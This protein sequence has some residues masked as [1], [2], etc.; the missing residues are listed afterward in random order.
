MPNE[1]AAVARALSLGPAERGSHTGAVGDVE[2]VATSTGIGTARAAEATARLFDALTP[3][4][5]MVVGIAGGVDATRV[6]AV[7]LPEVV[8]DDGTGREYRPSPLGEHSAH[9]ASGRLSTSDEYSYSSARIAE[10][11]AHGVVAVDMETAAV[12]AVCEER[13][14]PWSVVRAIS[15]PVVADA[16]DMV[17]R[18]VHPDGSPNVPAALRYTLT[19]PWRIPGLVR[20]GRDASRACRAAA[21]G[22]AEQI[23]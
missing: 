19:H 17:L 10:L 20:L 4:H 6:G 14:R 3:D 15:D 11:I 8:V 13:D 22:A 23:R 12:A 9:P 5:V 1:L 2:I 21:S 7:V 18:L 16:D